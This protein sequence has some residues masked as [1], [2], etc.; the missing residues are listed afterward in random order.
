MNDKR[1]D[2]ERINRVVQLVTELHQRQIE[3]TIPKLM[4]IEKEIYGNGKPGLLKEYAC[5]M[6][7]FN[8]ITSY[9]N[10]IKGMFLTIVIGLITYAFGYGQLYMK[11]ENIAKELAA[12]LLK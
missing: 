12:H 2:D 9:A 3:V 4:R 8:E 5:M 1:Q 7:K 10:W 6:G 11:V